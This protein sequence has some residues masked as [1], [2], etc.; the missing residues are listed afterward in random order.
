MDK[1]SK[2]ETG[3]PDPLLVELVQVLARAAAE[4]DYAKMRKSEKAGK[5]RPEDLPEI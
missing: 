3:A 5:R 4:R 2:T 1:I